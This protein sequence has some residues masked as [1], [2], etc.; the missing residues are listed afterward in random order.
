MGDVGPLPQL[1][2]RAAAGQW[3]RDA[4]AAAALRF[5][6]KQR[7]RAYHW[8][9]KVCESWLYYTPYALAMQDADLWTLVV[10]TVLL[11]GE[12]HSREALLGHRLLQLIPHRCACEHRSC[13]SPQSL[14][15]SRLHPP[16]W[17]F[18]ALQCLLLNIETFSIHLLGFT[19]SWVC[20]FWLG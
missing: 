19:G 14:F 16:C 11:P 5:L 2:R 20:W 3:H 17:A 10:S 7:P 1:P 9:S 6:S 8:F 12:R 13:D 4:G 18:Q 15:P